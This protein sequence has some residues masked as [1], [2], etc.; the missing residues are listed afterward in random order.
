MS[1]AST[2]ASVGNAPRLESTLPTLSNPQV[3]SD[4]VEKGIA[5][6]NE[7]AN[8]NETSEVQSFLVQPDSMSSNDDGRPS[9]V[10]TQHTRTA[11]S[12]F[13]PQN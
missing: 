2:N 8:K 9:E 3:A 6:M 12:P 5:G 10:Q 1:S 11:L 13:T 7:G 4:P